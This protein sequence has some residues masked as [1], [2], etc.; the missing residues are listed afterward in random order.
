MPTEPQDRRPS[1]RKQTAASKRR[2]EREIESALSQGVAI[3]DDDGTRLEV[4]VGDVKGGHEAALIGECGLSFGGLLAALEQSQSAYH[5]AVLLWFARL[6]N[7]REGL[8]FRETLDEVG[9]ADYLSRDVG[10]PA[11]D[12][13]PK[14]SVDNS[15]TQDD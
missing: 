10:E 14:A 11:K 8:S 13:R 12:A 1:A 15:S 7:E 5:L 4:R 3:N 9:Y 2:Q 6:V